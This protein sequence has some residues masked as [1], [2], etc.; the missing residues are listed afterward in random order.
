LFSFL[1]DCISSFRQ[2]EVARSVSNYSGASIIEL[3]S[4]RP[5]IRAFVR[6]GSAIFDFTISASH[7]SVVWNVAEK[8]TLP[9][10]RLASMRFMTQSSP[11]S[12]GILY[13]RLQRVT[14]PDSVIIQFVLLKMG[15]LMLETCRGL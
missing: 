9:N 8:S 13:S 12:T 14:I 7:W 2:K 1:S 15:M 11:L 10:K 4:P 5:V 3:G 6:S